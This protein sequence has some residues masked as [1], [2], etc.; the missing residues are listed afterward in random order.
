MIDWNV[1]MEYTKMKNA[2]CFGGDTGIDADF[3][4]FTG[5]VKNDGEPTTADEHNEQWLIEVGSE[6]GI[7]EEKEY[8]NK[9][10]TL[11]ICGNEDSSNEIKDITLGNID[12]NKDAQEENLENNGG[13]SLFRNIFLVLLIIFAV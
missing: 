7:E 8:A 4:T 1:Y 11:G 2:Q 12:I 13:S 3:T 9:M 10:I 5:D 6:T